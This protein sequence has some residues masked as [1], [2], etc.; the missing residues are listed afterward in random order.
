MKKEAQEVMLKEAQDAKYTSN[1]DGTFTI[2]TPN[3][4]VKGTTGEDKVEVT[5]RGVSLGKW[6][7]TDTTQTFIEEARKHQ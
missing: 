2:T 4:E 3:I 6:S 1:G 5:F 7:I